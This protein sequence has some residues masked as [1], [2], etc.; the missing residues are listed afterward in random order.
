V[1][2]KDIFVQDGVRAVKLGLTSV[3]VFC[4]CTQASFWLVI[5]SRQI[6]V[7]F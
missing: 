1:N 6:R 7:R 4:I 2:R 5:R 3:G